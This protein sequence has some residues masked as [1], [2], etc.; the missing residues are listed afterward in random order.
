MES[1]ISKLSYERTIALYNKLF[2]DGFDVCR[3][4]KFEGYVACDRDRI[5]HC[6]AQIRKVIDTPDQM[7]GWWGN[8]H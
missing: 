7:R 2:K 1:N 4:C 8:N 6:K 3:G 5:C